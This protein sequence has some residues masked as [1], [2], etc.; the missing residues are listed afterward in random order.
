MFS[1]CGFHDLELEHEVV[2]MPTNEDDSRRGK[3]QFC[4]FE[5]PV[6]P[7]PEGEDRVFFLE[8]VDSYTVK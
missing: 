3:K 4:L 5:S 6:V 2:S 8:V 7:K 1:Q